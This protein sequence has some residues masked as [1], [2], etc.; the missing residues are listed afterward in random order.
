[1]LGMSFFGRLRTGPGSDVVG[2]GGLPRVLSFESS[3]A[4]CFMLSQ[5]NHAS[6]A[7]EA[8]ES[9]CIVTA[10]RSSKVQRCARKVSLLKAEAARRQ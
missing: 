1:M 10:G 2:R 3:F 7:V 8:F 9:L 6:T 4:T 5:K